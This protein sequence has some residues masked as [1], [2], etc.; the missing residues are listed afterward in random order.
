MKATVK[1]ALNQLT[2][3]ALWRAK[4]VCVNHP[5]KILLNGQV[6]LKGRY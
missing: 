1:F 4:S 5:D 3:F 6:Q 2:L